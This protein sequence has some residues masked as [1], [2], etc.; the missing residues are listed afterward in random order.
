MLLALFALG[1][2]VTV[3]LTVHLQMTVRKSDECILHD[4]T[5]LIRWVVRTAEGVEGVVPSVVFR[6]PPPDD[7]LLATLQRLRTQF[8]R[9]RRLW[10]EKERM[11]RFNM[12]LTTMRTIQGWDL[13]TV[14]MQK[15]GGDCRKCLRLIVQLVRCD[16]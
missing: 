8:E 3:F 6:F 11:V 10:T 12:L 4:N 16:G 7:Q 5:D 14:W 2:T 15:I 13:K 1:H 9:L